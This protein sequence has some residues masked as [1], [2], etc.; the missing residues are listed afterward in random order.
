MS[1]INSM[2]ARLSGVVTYDDNTTGT[3]HAQVDENGTVWSQDGVESIENLRQVSWF[4][5]T[6]YQYWVA[7]RDAINALPFLNFTYGADCCH[8]DVQKA[9]T[10][11]VV[12]FDAV[13]GLNDNTLYSV[14][15]VITGVDD[16]IRIETPDLVSVVTNLD[17]FKTRLSD[18][19]SEIMDEVVLT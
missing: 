11:M 4:N 9:V 3:F 10:D 12:R 17:D 18:M 19:F 14:S 13:F 5:P 16:S 6:V 2:V 8:P 1:K 15:V 7:L